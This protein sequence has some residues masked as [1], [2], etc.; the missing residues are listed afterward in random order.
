[1]QATDRK[2]RYLT[3]WLLSAVGGLVLIGLGLSLFGEAV[4]AKYEQRAWFWFG[5]LSLIV[6]NSGVSLVGQSVV[7]RI[8]YLRE[9]E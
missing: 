1:M 2:K 5:T 6:V 9:G 8:K 4:I 3:Y 7:Y